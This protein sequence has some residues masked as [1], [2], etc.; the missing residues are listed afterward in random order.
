MAEAFLCHGQ[1]LSGVVPD[2]GFN[3]CP[4]RTLETLPIV[5]LRVGEGIFQTCQISGNYVLF[6]LAVVLGA[7][8]Q[9]RSVSI[10]A[11][12]FSL[13]H[14]WVDRAFREDLRCMGPF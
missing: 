12:K 14:L 6:P 11:A 10:Q 2:D 7:P 5:R 1:I 13:R 8:E 9:H 4:G 3:M